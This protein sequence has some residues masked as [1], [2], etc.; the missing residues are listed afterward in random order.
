MEGKMIIVSAPSGAGK[1][2]IVRYLLEQETSLSFSISAT[3]RPKRAGE[4]DR[5]DYYFLSSEDFKKKIEEGDFLEWQEVYPNQFYGTFKSEVERIWTLGNHV[6][7]D[8]DVLGGIEMKRLFGGRALSIFIKPPDIETLIERL[9]SRGTEDVESFTQRI[10]K[11][12]FELSFEDQFDEVVVNDD[13]PTAQKE[14]V[15]LVR[16]FTINN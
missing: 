10:A 8:I 2:S 9:K 12:E 1:T 15:K 11:V 13:L 3:S 14:V 4:T 16:Q 6:V 7:F 5:K